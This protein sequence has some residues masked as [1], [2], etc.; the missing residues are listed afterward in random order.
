MCGSKNRSLLDDDAAV[1]EDHSFA[2]DAYSGKFFD[3]SLST[4]RAGVGIINFS[5]NPCRYSSFSKN[6]RYFS[7]QSTVCM[8]VLL[9]MIR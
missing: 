3:R 2:S 8:S 7:S 9:R 4:A 5:Q 1:R 6:R